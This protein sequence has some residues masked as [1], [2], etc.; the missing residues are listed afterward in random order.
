MREAEIYR[1]GILAGILKEVNRKEYSFRYVDTYFYD[2]SKAAVSLT[3]SKKK[4]E[5]KNEFLF[6]F[7]FFFL[8]V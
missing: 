5:Y 4:Q 1:N 3:L 7:F 8:I 2:T 6:P